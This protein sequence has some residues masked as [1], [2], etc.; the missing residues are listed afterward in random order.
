MVRY[1]TGT[2]TASISV[3]HGRPAAF[4][5]SHFASTEGVGLAELFGRR[6]DALGDRAELVE[7]EVVELCGVQAEDLLGLVGRDVPETVLEN[8]RV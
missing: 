4:R 3:S 1:P 6:P 8:S 7:V 5:S 2:G